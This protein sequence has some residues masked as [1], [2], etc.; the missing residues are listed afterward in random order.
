MPTPNAVAAR[1]PA[2]DFFYLFIFIHPQT[3]FNESHLIRFRPIGSRNENGVIDQLEVCEMMAL[4][5]GVKLKL[6]NGSMDQR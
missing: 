3:I 6:M 4:I 2:P 5:M 1:W